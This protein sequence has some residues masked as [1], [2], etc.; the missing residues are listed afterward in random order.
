MGTRPGAGLPGRSE[1]LNGQ[2]TGRGWSHGGEAA[3]APGNRK[4]RE[5][6]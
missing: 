6:S 2:P 5:T 1:T 3:V 4:R